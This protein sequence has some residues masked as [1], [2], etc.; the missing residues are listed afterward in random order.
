MKPRGEAGGV[1]VHPLCSGV[2]Q[3]EV[4]PGS[5]DTTL[6]CRAHRAL[7]ERS[8]SIDLTSVCWSRG[9]CGAERRVR[10]FF[11]G[12]PD[13]SRHPRAPSYPTKG[14]FG[15]R[16]S[17][18]RCLFASA[19]DSVRPSCWTTVVAVVLLAAY[20]ATLEFPKIPPLHPPW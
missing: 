15:S 17:P 4:Q 2:L 8:C 11:G 19:G 14:C 1:R 18:H 20:A 7:E 3:V 16:A 6:T 5:P 13:I 12:S 10:G 9:E